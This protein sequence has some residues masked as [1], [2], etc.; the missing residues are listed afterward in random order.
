MVASHREWNAVI[1]YYT[2]SDLL[3]M[4]NTSDGK[5]EAELVIKELA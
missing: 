4:I 2:V 1:G 3:A 5:L